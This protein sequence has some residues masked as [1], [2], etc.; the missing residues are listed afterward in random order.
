MIELDK[1]FRVDTETLKKVVER[2]QEELQE[3]LDASGTNIVC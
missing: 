1:L 3:G 2:F